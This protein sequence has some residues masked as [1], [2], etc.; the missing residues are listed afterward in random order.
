MKTVATVTSKGQ[1]TIPR[2]IRRT[3]GLQKGDRLEFELER[4]RVELRAAKPGLSSAG[5]LRMHLPK[6]CEAK[7]TKEMDAGLAAQ[8]ARKYQGT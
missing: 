6:D 1:V 5:I 8:L 7:T 4:G 3:L 2:I